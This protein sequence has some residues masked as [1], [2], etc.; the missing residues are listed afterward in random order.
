MANTRIKDISTT[1][2][3]AANDD[4]LAIDGST[5]GTR[6]ILTSNLGGSDTTYTLSI[7]NN[8][9]TLA[10]SDGND[11]TVTLPVYAGGVS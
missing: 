2:S 8:V 6:K 7:T 9:L 11:S 1:A 10:G 4:Y 5:N 3:A